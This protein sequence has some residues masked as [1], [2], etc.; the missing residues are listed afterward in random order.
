ML[1][2]TAY[3]PPE[4]YS[5][6]KD[7]LPP[8][9]LRAS[10]GHFPTPIHRLK[11][12]ISSADG[13]A[14]ARDKC[15]EV[16]VKR[17][18]MTSFDLGGNKIRKLEFLLAEAIAKG[19]D[20][21]ITIGGI[22]SNHARATAVAAR[23]LGLDPYL[24]LRTTTDTT[25]SEDPGLVGN[26]LLS[27]MVNAHISLVSLDDYVKYG[28]GFLLNKL[29][30]TLTA[31]GKKPYIIPM[32]GTNTLGAWGYMEAVDE[33]S[34]QCASGEGLP[35]HFDHI[36]FGCGSGGTAA[37]VVFGTHLAK[38]STQ[39]HGVCVCDD[40]QYFF[41]AMDVAGGEMGLLTSSKESNIK[42]S[43]DIST[44][45]NGQGIGYA[46]STAEELQFI[47]DVSASSGVMFDPVYSGKAL[48]HLYTNMLGLSGKPSSLL[49]KG[50][51]CCSSSETTVFQPHHKILFIHTG[52][53]FGMYDKAAQLMS[54]TSLGSGKQ[55][56]VTKLLL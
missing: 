37:G 21:V 9:S 28:G 41:D 43:K 19:H 24:I 32:G 10:L 16:Y 12:P 51:G 42:S 18:D 39:V 7:L 35:H 38:S 3:Q 14:L 55:G 13:A 6:V 49:D 34:K 30:E 1:T 52:G 2:T 22:Q 29:A 40:P 26:L 53:L 5:T 54:S 44:M 15:P 31:Q 8:P 46:Q 33:I 17:D 50:E 45:Y 47:C 23:Q 11:L 56:G 25:C 48:Y 36:V 27:R 20:C 4:W